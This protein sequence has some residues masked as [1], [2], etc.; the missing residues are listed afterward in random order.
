M[1]KLT[2]AA[3]LFLAAPLSRPSMLLSYCAWV[4]SP[5]HRTSLCEYQ[6]A[7]F[8]SCLALAALAI[9]AISAPRAAAD[10]GGVSFWLP[11]QYGS[12]AA[13]APTPGWSMPL[14]LYNYGGAIGAGRLLPRGRLL[15]SGLNEVVRRT[16]HRAYLHARHY[17]PG[18][19]AELLA[20]VRAGLHL[21][22]GAHRPR[23]VARV[24]VGLTVRRQRSLS[25]CTAILEFRRPQLH[26]LSRGQHP[27]RQLRS[28]PV[29]QHRHRP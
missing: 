14:V 15:S 17:Y 27:G 25:D 7:K 18:R 1:T 9:A 2:A 11:G 4:R 20:R 21:H 26:D 28:Q 19:T 22:V 23:P 29:V 8:Y 12:F 6:L 5:Q 10:E 13:A 24:A 3:G 16:V